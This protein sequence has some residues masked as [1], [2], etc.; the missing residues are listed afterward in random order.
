M[1]NNLA[2]MYVCTIGYKKSSSDFGY[3]PKNAK[4]GFVQQ[5]TVEHTIQ[6]VFSNL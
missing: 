1:A 4:N 5:G 2:C 6:I 3:T